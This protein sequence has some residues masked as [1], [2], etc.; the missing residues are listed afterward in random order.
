MRSVVVSCIFPA[1]AAAAAA[2][3]SGEAPVMWCRLRQTRRGPFTGLHR[4]T[5][6]PS[7]SASVQLNGR[8]LPPS[9]RP[10]TS[11][12]EHCSDVICRASRKMSKAPSPPRWLCVNNDHQSSH[13]AVQ[14]GAIITKRCLHSIYAADERISCA[15]LPRDAMRK[16]GLC[17]R[18]VSVRHV[19]VLYPDGWRYR[20]TSFSTR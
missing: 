18:P 16:R 10:K 5:T 11:S 15:F 9:K 6:T 4:A 12:N 20:Q 8:C 2:V 19:G 14:T 13:C 7:G 17:C 1:A 3:V